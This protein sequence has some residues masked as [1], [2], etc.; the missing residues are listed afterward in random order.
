MEPYIARDFSNS[1]DN[2]LV[3][4]EM[5][6]FRLKIKETYDSLKDIEGLMNELNH[7]LIMQD[8]KNATKLL[9]RK[10]DKLK[11]R[12]LASQ[13]QFKTIENAGEEMDGNCS[14]EDEEEFIG[15]IKSEMP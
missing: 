4:A 5:R 15:T 9:G 10:G 6:V 11:E 8:M 2:H 7:I 3:I 1:I 12:L 14:N 13:D